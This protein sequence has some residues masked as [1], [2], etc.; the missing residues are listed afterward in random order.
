MISASTPPV[1]AIYETLRDFHHATR[2]LRD[3]AR[4]GRAGQPTDRVGAGFVPIRTVEK[5]VL[6]D[7]QKLIAG[8][9]ERSSHRRDAL[10][11]V[12]RGQQWALPVTFIAHPT[13]P[14]WRWAWAEAP[15]AE[16]ARRGMTTRV[17]SAERA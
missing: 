5:T 1:L 9:V 2:L 17:I 14:M 6:R 4:L 3:V 7:G 16:L 10:T 13:S 15:A 11:I 12:D 8:I